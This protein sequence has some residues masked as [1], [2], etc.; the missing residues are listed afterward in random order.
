MRS[1]HVSF[2]HGLCARRAARREE[3]ALMPSLGYFILNID[4]ILFSIGPIAIH[5]YG[6]A[7]VVA[8]TIGVFVLRRWSRRM[9]VHDDQLYGLVLYTA[10]AGLIGGRLY[11]VIQQPDLVSN[12]LQNPVHILAVWQGGM[13][14]FG[15]IFAGSITLFFLAPRY[16]LSPFFGLD[17]GALF[18]VVGQI[19]GRLGNVVNGDILGAQASP[20]IVS[21]PANTCVGSPCIAYVADPSITPSWS[22]VYVNRNSFAP[23]FI[24]YQPAQVYEMLMNI[25][26]LLLI[27]PLRY[28]LP[29]VKSGYFFVGYVMLYAISQFIV[30]FWRNTEP[31]TPFLGISAHLKQAQWTA[32]LVFLACIPLFFLVWRF[33]APWPYSRSHPAPWTPTTGSV[34]VGK[35][36]AEREADAQAAQAAVDLPPW[37]PSRPVGGALRN[38]FG[39]SPPREKPGATVDS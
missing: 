33:S 24:A 3:T 15:A 9:G 6:L 5:W 13:A 31:F 38:R 19:F 17:G 34:L 30:F 18:A 22:F 39:A 32:I 10:I 26:M 8:I 23:T 20:G 2:R 29:R 35:P 36:V 1:G 27:F 11:Y 21:I 28:A 14:F 12:Y 37:Q 7:Y 4:P 16:G 25:G